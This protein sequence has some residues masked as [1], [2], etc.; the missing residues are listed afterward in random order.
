M[1]GF[2]GAMDEE[3]SSPR[4]CLSDKADASGGMSYAAFVRSAAERCAAITRY[5]IAH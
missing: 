5:M 3:L 2:I 1:T 4:A